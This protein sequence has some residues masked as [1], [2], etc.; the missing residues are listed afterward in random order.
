MQNQSSDRAEVR[1]RQLGDVEREGSEGL[2]H[3]GFPADRDEGSALP[4]L[5]TGN[6]SERPHITFP[7]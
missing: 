7:C 4:S 5:L 2:S 6:D 1:R 3:D